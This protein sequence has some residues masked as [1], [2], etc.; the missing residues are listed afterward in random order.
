VPDD[1]AVVGCDDIPLAAHAI[2][3][4]TTVH[5]PFFE[6]GETA[7]RVLLDIIAGKTGGPKRV[8]L[9]VHLVRRGSCGGGPEVRATLTTKE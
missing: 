2:P 7:V 3:P 1:C 8:L 4:L 5:V 6:T 9:P